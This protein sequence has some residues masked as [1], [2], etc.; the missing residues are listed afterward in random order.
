MPDLELVVMVGRR[1]H[2]E[3]CLLHPF[4]CSSV[5]SLIEVMY[6]VPRGQKALLLFFRNVSQLVC[7][8]L[9]EIWGE[10]YELK[11]GSQSMLEYG[12]ISVVGLCAY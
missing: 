6:S 11:L 2:H 12:G 7:L 5:P 8:K 1:T 10:R 4:V 9:S 3:L